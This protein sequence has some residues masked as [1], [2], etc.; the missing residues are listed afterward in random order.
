MGACGFSKIGAAIVNAVMVYVVGDSAFANLDDFPV[1]PYGGVPAGL[2]DWLASD[3]IETASSFFAKPFVFPQSFVLARIN[4]GVLG[5]REP[6]PPKSI[7]I[8][9]PPVEQYR[10]D[11]EP[12]EPPRKSEC[13]VGIDLFRFRFLV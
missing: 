13:A 9:R 7:T 8:A 1:H 4:Y 6:N 2:S 11:E 12:L 10:S 5:L 3:G